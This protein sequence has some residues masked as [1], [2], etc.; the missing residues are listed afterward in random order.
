MFF[1]RWMF[2]VHESLHFWGPCVKRECFYIEKWEFLSFRLSNQS[3]QNHYS[4]SSNS[5][6]HHP[7]PPQ[8]KKGKRKTHTHTCT[9]SSTEV[10]P[11]AIL[12]GQKAYSPSMHAWISHWSIEIAPS[13]RRWSFIHVY[14]MIV[15]HHRKNCIYGICRCISSRWFSRS[16]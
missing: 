14:I 9:Q 3:S 12:K 10:P 5:S 2:A 11:T 16:V 15:T 7:P 8:K 1:L 6:P 4:Y 13:D